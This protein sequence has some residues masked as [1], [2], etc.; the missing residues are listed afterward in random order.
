[1][2]KYACHIAAIILFV[3]Y[4]G[5]SF[6]Q[7]GFEIFEIHYS[8]AADMESAVK[9]LLSEN[10]KMS[11]S[12]S[13]NSIIVKD[14][15]RVLKQVGQMIARLDRRPKN[16]RIE[17]EFIEK[18]H[19]SQ[20]GVDVQW[21]VGGAGWSIGFIPGVKRDSISA[22]LTALQSDFKG[23][24]KQFLVIMEN[25]P[26]RIFVGE[27]IPFT[28]YFLQYGRN[29][30]Y[31]TGNTRFKSVGVSFTVRVNSAENGKLRVILEPEVSYY[32]RK[33]NSFPV[34]NAATT[35]VMDDPGTVVIASADSGDDS[36]NVNFL[37]GIKKKKTKSEFA[38]ILTARSV[39]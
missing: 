31:I 15:P 17:V 11:V 13:S 33:R 24:K 38:M 34:K 37:R 39:E 32:D 6:A 2:M 1:M 19:L 30:G 21:R 36:F 3:A 27:E 14:N 20:I 10:G 5:H 28:D 16:I 35:I 8:N 23:R 26:G 4:P 12:V 29:H 18:S 22:N 7:S 9:T 25:R